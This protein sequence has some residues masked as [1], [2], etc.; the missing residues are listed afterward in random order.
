[1]VSTFRSKLDLGIMSSES[2]INENFESI[3]LSLIKI[4]NNIEKILGVSL[5]KF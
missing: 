3:L 5:I 2:I 4:P 1:M